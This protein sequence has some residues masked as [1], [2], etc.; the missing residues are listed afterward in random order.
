[1]EVAARAALG[2]TTAAL[3]TAT[4]QLDALNAALGTV[5]PDRPGA[6]TA[7]G[8][9]AQRDTVLA[10]RDTLLAQRDG[11]YRM[12][13]AVCTAADAAPT[14]PAPAA[15][16]WHAV[17]RPTD[18]PG[19]GESVPRDGRCAVVR[20]LVVEDEPCDADP[21]ALLLG[22]EGFEPV[23]AATAAAALTEFD[24]AGAGV[25]LLDL[26][27]P[28]MGGAQVY[29]ALRARSAAVAVIVVSARDG[30]ADKVAGLGLGAD[31]YITKPYSTRELIARIRAVLRRRG[32]GI[33]PVAGSGSG[34]GSGGRVARV[35][36]VLWA[37]PV[38]MDLERHVVS[39]TAPD[40]ST[41]AVALPLKQFTLLEYLLRRP[42]RVLTRRELLDGVWPG[43]EH[44]AESH[45][46]EVH[47]KRLRAT[48][49]P[50]PHRPRH[51][52]T[53]R[54]VGYIFQP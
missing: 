38:R 40:G 8:L 19:S 7:R 34:S 25:V 6:D 20:V 4:V 10:H 3:D 53:L 1:V 5:R 35:Q 52:L 22:R 42:G 24:R 37:G 16:W 14:A 41:A 43:A 29:T 15:G 18:T 9:L 28:G 48:L 12:L 21:L 13:G 39:V 45:T 50:D 51:L 46:V 33:A 49:E 32:Q 17:P 31:D 36:S 2:P 26:M 54:G 47:I 23:V 11:L 27:A 44:L 30:E